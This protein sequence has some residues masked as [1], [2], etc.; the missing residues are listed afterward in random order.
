MNKLIGEK[1][2]ILIIILCSLLY[3]SSCNNENYYEK[4]Y[5]DYLYRKYGD[6][7][8]VEIDMIE[9]KK[10]GFYVYKKGLKYY[11]FG[12]NEKNKI[13]SPME[14]NIKNILVANYIQIVMDI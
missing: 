9:N 2:N 12:V 1:L 4:E 8:N 10:S 6:I 13:V 5:K 7:S 14:V 3:L 11:Y